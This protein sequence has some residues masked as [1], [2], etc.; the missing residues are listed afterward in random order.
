MFA[1]SSH[2]FHSGSVDGIKINKSCLEVSN[3]DATDNLHKPIPDEIATASFE[4]NSP[5]QQQYD[6]LMSELV[7][8]GYHDKILNDFKLKIYNYNLEYVKKYFDRDRF[9]YDLCIFSCCMQRQHCKYT[10][11]LSIAQ[12]CKS[13][14]ATPTSIKTAIVLTNYILYI[15]KNNDKMRKENLQRY[16]AIMASINQSFGDIYRVCAQNNTDMMKAD[17]YYERSF[18]LYP[19][20]ID[21]NIIHAKFVESRLNNWPKAHKLFERAIQY[22]NKK[23]MAYPHFSYAMALRYRGLYDEAIFHF[24]KAI[25]FRGPHLRYYSEYGECLFR[26]GPQWYKQSL[27]ILKEAT[28][29]PIHHNRPALM[30]SNEM[31]RA[32]RRIIQIE[33]YLKQ[34]PQIQHKAKDPHTN[35]FEFKQN[36]CDDLKWNENSKNNT[37]NQ[38]G[39]VDRNH[40][41]LLF[42]DENKNKNKKEQKKQLMSFYEQ[43]QRV[44]FERFWDRMKFIGEDNGKRKDLYFKTICKLNYNYL[45]IISCFNEKILLNEINM[46]QNDCKYFLTQIF[47]WK[48]QYDKFVQ[49]LKHNDF[50]NLYFV[51]LTKC[52]IYNKKILMKFINKN[53]NDWK[54]IILQNDHTRDCFKI[55]GK[56]MLMLLENQH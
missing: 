56:K 24:E 10:H 48:C 41:V 30:R 34:N 29:I 27:K 52:G 42:K 55:D 49:W 28:R 25:G 45:S 13:K 16:L 14:F 36:D 53:K 8:Q 38:N 46:T 15:H 19:N 37:K 11:C 18:I 4:S 47:N 43:R 9:C 50:Y 12:L 23:N 5:S 54:N 33:Q 1:E 51:K 6:S 39:L 17:E 40:S 2:S 22:K 21:R 35:C 3:W 26:K 31:L 7:S 44:E 20:N 32:Q